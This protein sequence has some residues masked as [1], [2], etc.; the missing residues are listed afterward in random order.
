M[1]ETI[2]IRRVLLWG[3]LGFLIVICV[4]QLATSSFWE[5]GSID[6]GQRI[7]TSSLKL[8]AGIAGAQIIAVNEPIELDFK[9]K[10]D[11]FGLR[12][13]YVQQHSDLVDG[14]YSP[15]LALFGQITSHKPWWGLEGQYC[16]GSG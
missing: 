11:V 15:S 14:K 2:N 16:K 4:Y 1:T 10:E 7:V 5:S 3:F 6:P 8:G 9:S 12:K 13:K